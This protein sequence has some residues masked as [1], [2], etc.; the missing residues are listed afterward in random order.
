RI[1]TEATLN[2]V[3]NDTLNFMPAGPLYDPQYGALVKT[4]T[5]PK[6]YLLLNEKK[7]WITD[8]EVF[9]TLKY[10][11]TWIEDIDQRLLNKYTTAEEITDKTTH[12]QYT[13]IK[14]TNNAKVYRLEPNPTDNALTIKRHIANEAIFKALG[15]RDDRIVT[16]SDT[17][18][19]TDGDVLDTVE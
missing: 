8:E 15:F 7:Y 12:P 13:L 9:N 14:Y 10:Q 16:V 4:V 19:Y 17:E 6:V 11:W 5:D 18:V 1:T 2:T 3:P